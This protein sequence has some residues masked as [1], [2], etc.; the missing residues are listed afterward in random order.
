[1]K[2]TDKT[3]EGTVPVPL[4]ALRCAIV[5]YYLFGSFRI[6]GGGR[7]SEGEIFVERSDFF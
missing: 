2:S 5:M 3:K 7:S 6:W 4:T 1:M